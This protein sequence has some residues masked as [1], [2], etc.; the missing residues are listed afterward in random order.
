MR[1]DALNKKHARY[2]NKYIKCVQGIMYSSTEGVEVGKFNEINDLLLKV[3]RF[4]NQFKE[5]AR[6]KEELSEWCYMIPNLMLYSSVGFLIGIKTKKVKEEI[7]NAIEQLFEKTLT[8]TSKTSE[9]LDTMK[10][11]GELDEI[12][13]KYIKDTEDANN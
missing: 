11:L 13:D 4:A 6:N 9:I 2:L 8:M 12:L 1:V 7:N 5:N 3:V 10:A